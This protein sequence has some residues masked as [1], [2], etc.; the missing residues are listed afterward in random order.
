MEGAGKT[1]SIF[2]E[3]YFSFS[4][5]N[6]VRLLKIH[7]LSFLWNDENIRDAPLDIQ[8]IESWRDDYILNVNFLS[9]F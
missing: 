4:V 1:C 7:K 3:K 2:G 8:G 9:L 5:E 6:F